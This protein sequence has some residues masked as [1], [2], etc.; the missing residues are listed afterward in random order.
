MSLLAASLFLC[1]GGVAAARPADPAT[2]TVFIRVTGDVLTDYVRGWKQQKA[3][4]DVQIA[5]GTGFLVS[6]EGYVLTNRHV[7]AGGEITTARQRQEQEPRARSEVKRIEIVL[8]A[9]DG[10]GERAFAASVIAD[11]P[12][13]DLALLSVPG[14]DLPWLPL[15]DSDALNLG[16][17]VTAWG[18]PLGQ[19]VEVGRTEEEVGRPE[20]EDVAPEVAASPGSVAALRLDGEGE[21][22]YIQT[23]ATLNPGNSGGPL[24]DEDGYVVGIVRMK[25]AAGDHVGFAIPVNLAKDFVEAHAPAGLPA[26]LRLGSLQS[27][28]WKGLRLRLPD[29]MADVSPSRLRWSSGGGADEVSLIVDRVA[30]PWSVVGLEGHLLAGGFG[31]P[32]STPRRRRPPSG[33]ARDRFG[34]ALG[35][36][37]ALEYAVLDLGRERLV[38]RFVGPPLAV[39]Y[40]RSVLR[41]S[42]ES[43]EADRLLTAEVAAPVLV[44]MEH[45]ALTHPRAP[46]IYL[47]T[48]WGRETAE[49]TGLSQRGPADAGVASSPEGD[50]T[51]VCRTLWW[52]TKEAPSGPAEPASYRRREERLGVAYEIEG[53]FFPFGPGLLQIEFQEPEVK[54]KFIEGLFASWRK[55]FEPAGR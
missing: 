18:F 36:P 54:A 23:D 40:N 10:A 34:A 42:L 2:G 5:T 35:E 46:A 26:R 9:G 16:E 52:E 33:R 31:E 22:R 47:P 38:A 43:L 8:P 29:G 37:I 53:A 11:D 3:Q 55:A 12:R 24:V 17:S 49:G 7:V 15:G 13:L 28:E 1:F 27:F 50:F 41:R 30:S 39:A 51:V 19:A 32:A 45:A 14:L 21:A 44:R 25:L 20:Q 48:G 6:P 4:R